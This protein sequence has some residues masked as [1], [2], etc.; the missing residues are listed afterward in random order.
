MKKEIKLV[1]CLLMLVVVTV[2]SIFATGLGTSSSIVKVGTIDNSSVVYN[3]DIEWGNLVYDFV[4]NGGPDSTISHVFE[5]AEPGEDKI[6]ITNYSNV[7][8]N[9]NVQFSSN[10]PSVIGYMDPIRSS[11]GGKMYSILEEEPED[12]AT[13]NYYEKKENNEIVLIPQGTEFEANKY[14]KVNGAGSGYYPESGDIPAYKE[15]NG[16]IFVETLEYVLSLEGGSLSEMR[17]GATIGV[18]TVTLT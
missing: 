3:V 13:G 12:F 7:V 11:I 6:S 2:P 5:I 4:Q 16:D 17:P 8:V 1:A 15:E 10:V 14:Y 18:V 9:A